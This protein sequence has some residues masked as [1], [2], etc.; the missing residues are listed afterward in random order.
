MPN[1]AS[2]PHAIPG[3]FVVYRKDA[4]TTPVSP[5]P[6][7]ILTDVTGNELFSYVTETEDVQGS[8]WSKVAGGD[9]GSQFILNLAQ[10]EYV[11]SDQQLGRIGNRGSRLVNQV[12]S[13]Q[14]TVDSF[15]IDY[16]ELVSGRTMATTAAQSGVQGYKTL[17]HDMPRVRPQ[18]QAAV[19]YPVPTRDD[20]Y[21]V[22]VTFF[23]LAEVPSPVM[24]PGSRAF[25]EYPVML[26]AVL[27]EDQGLGVTHWGFEDPL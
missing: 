7:A 14:F 18:F 19:L 20:V 15:D 23:P 8:D 9:V 2:R 1:Q 13:A 5:L 22:A 27:Q 4:A 17:P 3:P 21:F 25:Q 16:L 11:R 26:E 12:T 10:P 24:V 6:K